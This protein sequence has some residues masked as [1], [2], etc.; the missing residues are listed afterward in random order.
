MDDDLD[1]VGSGVSAFRASMLVALRLDGKT[2]PIERWLLLHILKSLTDFVKQSGS[3][4]L[5]KPTQ[6]QTTWCDSR[7]APDAV[8][9]SRSDIL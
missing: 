9:D 6:Q 5:P 1:A 2:C 4:D 7:S 3:L 8:S